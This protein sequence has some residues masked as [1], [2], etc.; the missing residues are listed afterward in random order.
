MH[1]VYYDAGGGPP[2]VLLHGMFGDHLDWAPVLKDLSLTYRV[3]ALDLPGFGDSPKPDS[4]Y[5]PLLFIDALDQLFVECR[6]TTATLVANSFGSQIAMLFAL[7]R[8]ERVEGIVLINPAGFHRYSGP[9]RAFILARMP[10]QWL[11]SL[12]GR[13]F[14]ALFE[15]LF[16]RATQDTQRY[17]AKQEAKPSRP[18]WPQMANAAAQCIKL[19]TH[20]CFLD[21]LYRFQ[22]PV[23][24]IWGQNDPGG[25]GCAGAGGG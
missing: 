18:D 13:S 20:L 25:T 24:M 5:D 23:L 17:L 7:E 11:R 21:H 14:R 8:P 3:I 9:E 10:V 2:L 6:L 4:F 1:L 22:C 16:F 19:H 12:S 15:P